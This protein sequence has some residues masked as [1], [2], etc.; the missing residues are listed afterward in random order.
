MP[1]VAV[2]RRRPCPASMRPA[3]AQQRPQL[4]RRPTDRRGNRRRDAL[5]GQPVVGITHSPLI[6]LLWRAG[7][8]INEALSLAESD[9]D[10]G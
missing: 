4:P 2:G 6:V 7:L 10:P 5:R 9:L 3:T 8:R 1:L